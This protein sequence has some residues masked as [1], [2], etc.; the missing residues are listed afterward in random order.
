M[1]NKVI[2]GVCTALFNAFGDDYPIYKEEIKQS[3]KEPC[4]MVDLSKPRRTK[5]LNKRYYRQNTMSINYFPKSS[6]NYRVECNEVLEKLYLALEYITIDDNLVRGI[7]FDQEYSDGVMIVFVDYNFHTY[8]GLTEE[9]LME[10][11]EIC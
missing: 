5:V 4:F 11:L 8:E 7:N 9:T 3:L 10:E 6:D 1:I 2:S